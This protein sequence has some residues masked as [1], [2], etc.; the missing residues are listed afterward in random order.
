VN[1]DGLLTGGANRTAIC[2]EMKDVRGLSASA[3]P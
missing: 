2:T 1:A 3:C